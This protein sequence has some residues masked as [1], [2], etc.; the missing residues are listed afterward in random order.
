NWGFIGVQLAAK[1]ALNENRFLSCGYAQSPAI[2]I[3]VSQHLGELHIESCEVMNTGVSPDSKTVSSSSFGIFAD[4]VLEARVQSNIVTFSNVAVMDPN[5]EHRA[6]WL[7]GWLEQV[8]NVGDAQLIAGFS[9]QI[10][11][12]KFLG[13]GLTAL[14]EV[15]QQAVS[16]TIF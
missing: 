2:S 5:Q 11:D 1:V 15:A 8:I 14:V 10:L 12:N 7:R 3:G 9:A 6:V 4:L 13:P 16:D